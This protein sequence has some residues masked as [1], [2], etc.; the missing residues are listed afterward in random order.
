M[1]EGKGQCKKQYSM[2]PAELDSTFTRA[3][4]Q[5]RAHAHANKRTNE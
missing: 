5:T 3:H 2:A 4:T 1:E